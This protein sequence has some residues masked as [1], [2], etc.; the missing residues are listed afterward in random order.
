MTL[1]TIHRRP[2]ARW[3]LL[4]IPLLCLVG[5]AVALLVS[6]A[7]APPAGA[8]SVVVDVPHGATVTFTAGVVAILTGV[9]TPILTGLV[10]KVG[11]SNAIKAAISFV[12]IALL[13]VV[14]QIATQPTF[15]VWGVVILGVTTFV[16]HMATWIGI[17]QPVKAGGPNAP[18]N[19]A[20]FGS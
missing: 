10:T 6:V 16:T 15:E 7:L 17:W 2:D 1:P 18:G 9:V 19:G 12:F 14:N 3:V 8:Q 11:T 20:L 13:A 4:A 5:V